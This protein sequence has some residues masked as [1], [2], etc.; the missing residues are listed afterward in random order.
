MIIGSNPE[1]STGVVGTVVPLTILAVGVF[2]FMRS[3]RQKAQQQPLQPQYIPNPEEDPY[4]QRPMSYPVNP[5][6][7]IPFTPYVSLFC[8]P[9]LVN[10]YLYSVLLRTPPIHPHSLLRVLPVRSHTPPSPMVS[11]EPTPACPKCD[12]QPHR[13]PNFAIFFLPLLFFDPV[14]SLTHTYTTIIFLYLLL[15]LFEGTLSTYVKGSHI[16]I[17]T[18]TCVRSLLILK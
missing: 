13:S 4:K 1:H 8:N 18:R 17:L 2:L 15:L 9:R 11:V 6:T 5:V 10:L 3:R 12:C 16:R 14:E 7:T